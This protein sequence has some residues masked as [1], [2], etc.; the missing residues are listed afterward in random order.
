[1]RFRTRTLSPIDRL[2]ADVRNALVMSLRN[3]IVE[4]RLFRSHGHTT[5]RRAGRV[6]RLSQKGIR[7]RRP[8]SGLPRSRDHV[9]PLWRTEPCPFSSQA[10]REENTSPFLRY[11]VFETSY[12]RGRYHHVRSCVVFL[13]FRDHSP[14]R[15]SIVS[16]ALSSAEQIIDGMVLALWI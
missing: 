6:L 16:T 10:R 12:E 5:R 4:S 2:K 15:S 8:R 9:I 7:I 13:G 3:I 11:S 1:M 14:W